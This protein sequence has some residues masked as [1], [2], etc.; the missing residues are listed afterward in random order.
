M[1]PPSVWRLLDAAA[2]YRRGILP[3][4]GGMDDQPAWLIEAL[5]F[6]AGEL[7]TAEHDMAERLRKNAP[8][9]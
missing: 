4:A 6:A 7:T 9:T 8:K 1:L 5:R 3:G 2:E